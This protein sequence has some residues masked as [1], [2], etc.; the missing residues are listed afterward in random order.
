A[1]DQQGRELHQQLEQLQNNRHQNELHKTRLEADWNNEEQKLIEK[2]NMTFA[3]ATVEAGTVEARSGGALSQSLGSLRKQIAAIGHVNIDAIE[4]YQ[5]VEERFTFLSTQRDDLVEAS[6]Q[7]ATVIAEMDTI[8]NSRF[9]K[10]FLQLSE[11]FNISFRRLFGGG[12]AA[13]V[14][15]DPKHMLETGVEIEV[16]PPGKKVNHY[17]LLSG[18]EKTMIGIALMFAMLAV[19]PTPFCM[20]DEVDAALDEANIERF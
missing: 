19:R 6:S 8:M 5:E 12:E 10:A 15:S 14:L 16:H 2:F 11:Q 18:G 13:L 20:M 3:Q 17:N 9:K 7:L 1:L 4:E